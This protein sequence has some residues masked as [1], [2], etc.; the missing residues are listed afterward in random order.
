MQ[1]TSKTLHYLDSPI[2][3]PFLSLFIGV[4]IYLRH[5]VNLVILYATLTTF[6]TV[7][8][9]ELDWAAEQYKGWLSQTITFSLLAILQGINLFWLYMIIRVAYNVVFANIVADV[10]SED[11]DEDEENEDPQKQNE[12]SQ[13]AIPQSPALNGMMNGNGN[14]NG[15][16]FIS[17]EKKSFT[18]V[19]TEGKKEL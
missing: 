9:Y 17:E 13:K 19:V 10:R 6:R 15:T 16:G 7:G 14:E 1:Q 12:K 5:Y 11:E 2:V 18:Q 4:W 3:T 8:P